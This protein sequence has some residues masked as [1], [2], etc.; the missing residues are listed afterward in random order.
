MATEFKK[1]YLILSLVVITKRVAVLLGAF[2]LHKLRAD[3]GE[4]RRNSTLMQMK[5][6]SVNKY[7]I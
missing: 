4:G 7:N 6:S 1:T 3:A 2:A 5:A